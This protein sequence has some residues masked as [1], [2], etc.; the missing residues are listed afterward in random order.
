MFQRAGAARLVSTHVV[1]AGTCSC[2][3]FSAAGMHWMVAANYLKCFCENGAHCFEAS[4]HDGTISRVMLDT[5]ALKF[6]LKC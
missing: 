4:R 6:R 2:R 5:W 1:F 3:L